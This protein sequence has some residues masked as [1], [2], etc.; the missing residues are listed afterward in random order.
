MPK[1]LQ[2]SWLGYIGGLQQKIFSKEE[3]HIENIEQVLNIMQVTTPVFNHSIPWIYLLDYTTGKYMV[4][5]NS[6]QAMLGYKTEDFLEGG[7]NFTL[8]NYQQKHLQLFNEEIFPDRLEMLKK[9]PYQE[10]PNY[11][12]SYNFQFKNRKGE[13]INLLQRNTFFKSDKNNN[14]LM[15]FGVI[16]NV[17][18]F[19]SET[20]IIQVVEKINSL[21]TLEDAETV[22]KKSYF[23]NQEE[24]L[25]TRREKE[26]LPYLA[27]GLSSKEIANKLYLSEF[28]VINHRRN[29]MMKTGSLN[30]T[31]LV[32]FAL[33]HCII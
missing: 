27:S 22:F 6:L 2:T 30:V 11:I 18:H 17:N 29:M 13:Y 8:E 31:Q 4:V 7:I 1:Q 25:F 3:L 21:N 15:S 16:T 14:P 23:P 10:H 32:C 24:R 19:K 28:T 33:M 9:I 20:P 12:F 26:I 5:S